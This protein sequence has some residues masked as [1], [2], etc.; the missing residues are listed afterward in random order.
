MKSGAEYAALLCEGERP[1]A[2]SIKADDKLR[3]PD[4][5]HGSAKRSTKTSIKEK[6]T[7]L[8]NDEFSVGKCTV[9]STVVER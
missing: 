9:N 8:T 1:P 2:A 3:V 5:A 6:A 4:P 7:E